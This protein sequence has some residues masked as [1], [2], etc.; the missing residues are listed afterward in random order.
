MDKKILKSSYCGF[1]SGVRRAIKLAEDASIHGKVYTLGPIIHNPQVVEKLREKGII[2]I[3][4]IDEMVDNKTILIRSHG[5]TTEEEKE[6]KN[7]GLTIIDA[8][9]PKVKRAHRICEDLAENFS[10]V[11]IIGLASH[12][13]VKGIISRAKNNG[14][15]ISSIKEVDALAELKTA[16]VL[17]QTTFRK[18]KFFEILSE[19]VKKTDIVKIHN[20]ICEETVSRQ[21]ELTK[22]ASQVDVLIV[23]GGKNSSNTKRLFE[24][25]KELIS[26]YLIESPDELDIKWF[27]GNKNIGII[28]GAS[29]PMTLVNDVENYINLII[30]NK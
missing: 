26:T 20:T 9:C 21:E 28:T 6:L 15:A 2:P 16:G 13:E 27:E 7:R 18:E 8:T 30:H 23:I 12:P 1:C 25:G 29:T 10:K 5:I 17:V 11:I 4:S 22:I 3:K 24:K 14:I 19:I